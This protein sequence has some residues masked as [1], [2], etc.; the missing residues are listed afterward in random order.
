MYIVDIID[1]RNAYGIQS[2]VVLSRYPKSVFERDG[3]W[4]IGNDDFV[5]KFYRRK[6]VRG[7]S[8]WKAFGGRKFDIQMANG[9]SEKAD[10]QWWDYLHPEYAQLTYDYGVSTVEKLEECYVFMGGLHIDRLIVDEWRERNE[11]SNNY[12]KYDKRSKLHRK[13]LI[14]SRWSDSIT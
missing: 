7:P 4:L 10:G 3:I 14:V 2:M 13:H 6:V 12:R 8:H 11:P 5:F 1:H 9:E